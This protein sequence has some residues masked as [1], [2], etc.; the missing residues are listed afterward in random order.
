MHGP[1]CDR[2]LLGLLLLLCAPRRGTRRTPSF[3]LLSALLTLCL[4]Q[5]LLVAYCVTSATVPI[6]A[7][8]T[9]PLLVLFAARAGGSGELHLVWF[10]ALPLH[11]EHQT[12]GEVQVHTITS[13]N[14]QLLTVMVLILGHTS[15]PTCVSAYYRYRACA[16]RQSLFRDAKPQAEAGGHF[17]R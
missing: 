9:H 10:R 14:M 13:N 5:Y 12:Q 7:E 2:L 4:L 3:A 17:R 1:W 6:V 11:P 8:S 16:G 15:G